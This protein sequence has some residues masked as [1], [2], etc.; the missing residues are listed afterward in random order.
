MS[1]LCPGHNV[2]VPTPIDEPFWLM[3]VDK[4]VHTE[5]ESFED[6]DKNEWTI[7]NVVVRSYWYEKFQFGSRSYQL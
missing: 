2:E 5:L 3:L 6:G 1:L 4:G 7:G